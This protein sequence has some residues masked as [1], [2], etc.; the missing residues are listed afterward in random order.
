MLI[1]YGTITDTSVG[2]LF[3]AGIIPGILLGAS[4]IVV[5]IWQA[6]KHN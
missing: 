3:L 4:L 5:A 1:V 2:K 6:R